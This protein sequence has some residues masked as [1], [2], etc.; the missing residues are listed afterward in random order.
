MFHKHS[1]YSVSLGPLNLHHIILHDS[2]VYYY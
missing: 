2:F 1:P